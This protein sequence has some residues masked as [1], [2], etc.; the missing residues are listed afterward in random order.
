MNRKLNLNWTTTT[1]AYLNYT[2]FLRIKKIFGFG[3]TENVIRISVAEHSNG[4]NGAKHT[5]T[6]EIIIAML[7]KIVHFNYFFLIENGVSKI[8]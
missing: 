1:D 5:I 7:F 4:Q 2:L 8:N 3:G 6:N